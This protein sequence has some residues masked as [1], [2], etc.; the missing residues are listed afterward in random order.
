[1][2]GDIEAGRGERKP[3]RQEEAEGGA[4]GTRV[5]ECRVDGCSEGSGSRCRAHGVYGLPGPDHVQKPLCVR[6]SERSVCVLPSRPWDRSLVTL[7]SGGGDSLRDSWQSWDVNSFSGHKCYYL[8]TCCRASETWTSAND[9]M[10]PPPSS[11]LIF[12]SFLKAQVSRCPM[13]SVPCQSYFFLTLRKM[14]FEKA[15]SAHS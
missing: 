15:D 7:S 13:W 3:E 11:R 10:H 5:S 12:F 9:Q 1:M 4:S 8:P 14:M 6:H 2:S